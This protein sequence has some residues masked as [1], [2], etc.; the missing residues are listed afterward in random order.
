VTLG[1]VAEE[2]ARSCDAALD[3]I[4]AST[5]PTSAVA[6][7]ARLWSFSDL[8]L[9]APEHHPREF[10]LQQQLL[11]TPGIEDAADAAEVVP[12]ALG[13]L[14][15]PRRL[16]AAAGQVGA[17]DPHDDALDPIGLPIDGDYVRTIAWTVA[18]NGALLADGLA[19]GL[20]STGARLGNELTRSLLRGWGADPHDLAA[21]R[22]LAEGWLR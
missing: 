5:R 8:F 12:A 20:P 21:A 3:A 2:H 15:V 9:S 17:L 7:L 13:V 18:L 1:E 19:T 22:T 14:D 11:V 4:G 16:L 6:A 10:R